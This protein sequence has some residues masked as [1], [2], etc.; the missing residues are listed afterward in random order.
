MIERVSGI[1]QASFGVLL[2][3]VTVKMDRAV[4]YVDKLQTQAF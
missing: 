4:K 1:S 2:L 3:I